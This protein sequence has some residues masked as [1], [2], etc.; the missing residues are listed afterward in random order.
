[1]KS[2]LLITTLV[3]ATSVA[4]QTGDWMAGRAGM[5]YSSMY[6]GG[7]IVYLIL[8]TILLI[9]LILL[10]WLWAFKLWKD[11]KRMK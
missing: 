9:G 3:A 5:M 1:M 6:G 2:A 10:V 8:R 4:A 11:I 7:S